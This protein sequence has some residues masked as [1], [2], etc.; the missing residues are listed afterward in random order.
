MDNEASVF[1]RMG[2][3]NGVALLLLGSLLPCGCRNKAQSGV[4][5]APPEVG[6]VTVGTTSVLLTRE[7]PGRTAPHRVAEVRPQASGLVLRRPFTEGADVKAGEV[8]Y[9]LDASSYEAAVASA[10]AAVATASASQATAAAAVVAAKAGHGTAVAAREAARAALA[11][12]QADLARAE[13]NVVPWR[14]RTERFRQL[15]AGNAISQQDLDDAAA[16]LA[17]AEAA[18]KSAA[19]AVQGAE[20]GVGRAEAA[21]EAAAAE[22]QRADAGVLAAQ[23]AAESAAAGL[24]AAQI[25]L[26]YTRITA[27]IAGRIGR[28]AVTTGALVTA[29]QPIALAV[30]QQLDPIYVDVPQASADLLRLQRRLADGRLSRNGTQNAV[31]LILEDGHPYP[32]AGTLQFRDVSIDQS[33]GSLI[34]RMVFPNPDGVLLPGMFVRAVVEEGVKEEAILVPQPAVSRDPMGNALAMLVNAANQVESRALVIDRAVR[35]QWL[36]ASGLKV[37]DCVVVE[38]LQRI[39]AGVTVRPVPVGTSGS[40]SAPAAAPKA[41]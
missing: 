29:H 34:L 18:V 39:R 14:L 36:V 6:T 31:K 10:K 40:V 15:V 16:A 30:I 33:T 19:A 22:I 4:P 41:N 32:H 3:W 26:G 12:A 24:K 35:D 38:G 28:S 7:L 1:R 5:P 2:R 27:P 25:T 37:G 13:A 17:Q 20:A 11:A 23:A 8:L 21:L 9:E